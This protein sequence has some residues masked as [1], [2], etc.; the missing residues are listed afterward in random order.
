VAGAKHEDEPAPRDAV[1]AELRGLLD[2]RKLG[3]AQLGQQGLC[4][5]V[6]VGGS[7]HK[8]RVGEFIVTDRKPS[9]NP[10]LKEA[11]GLNRRFKDQIE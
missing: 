1:C 6:I 5:V 3:R 11:I 10:A 2:G 8:K 9:G 7:A 4:L